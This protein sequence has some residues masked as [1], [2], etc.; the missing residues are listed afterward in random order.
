MGHH[1]GAYAAAQK[2][3]NWAIGAIVAGIFAI[4]GIAAYLGF[5][6]GYLQEHIIII[7]NNNAAWL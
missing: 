2:A 5:Y 3:K 6:F 1:T 4:I 7:N